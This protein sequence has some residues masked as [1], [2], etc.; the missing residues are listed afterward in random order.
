MVNPRCPA[1]KPRGFT[2]I[3]VLVVMAIV[4]TLVSLV[5]PRYYASLQRS[6]EAI[7]RH[8]LDAMRDAIDKFYSDRGAYPETLDDLVRGQYL[9][10]IPEDPVTQSSATWMVTPPRDPEARGQVFDVHSGA[11]GEGM[12]GSAYARW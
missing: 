6:K 2:L 8:D 5:A 7:L 10:V 11:P 3:E 9:R 4:A 1:A 12:D